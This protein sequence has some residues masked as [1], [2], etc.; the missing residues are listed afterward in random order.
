M[1]RERLT[2][3]REMSCTTHGRD[4]T[5]RHCEGGV[6]YLREEGGA[7]YC[8]TRNELMIVFWRG[9]VLGDLSERVRFR[10]RSSEL[11]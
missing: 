10:M 3:G 1:L 11:Q 5:D 9:R 6:E 8:T 7:E 2:A 4:E